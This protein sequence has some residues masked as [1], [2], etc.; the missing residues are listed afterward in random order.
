MAVLLGKW[1]G[2][3][4]TISVKRN[5]L[6][7]SIEQAQGE[8][9]VYSYDYA[10]RLWT[11]QLESTT[12]RRGL[13]GKMVAKWMRPDRT[14]GRRWLAPGE[15]RA[16]VEGR[17]RAQMLALYD[18]IRSGAAALSGSLDAQA[19]TGFERAI[20][21]DADRS[22]ADAAR[23]LD[24]YQPVGILPPDQYFSVVLQLAEGC[25]FNTCTFCTFYRDRAFRIK[26]PD[27][28]REHALA[29]R[30][31]LGD[32]LSLRRTIFLGDANALVIPMKLLLPLVDIVREVYD[33][34]RLG[35][36]YAFLDGFS[37]HKK[38]ASDYAA[39]RERGLKTVYIGMESGHAPL[40][41]FLKKPGQPEDVVEAVRAIK[42]GGVS[43]GVIV[44]L[45]AGG[46][47]Y[48]AAHVRDTID[49]INA[50]GLDMDDLIYFSELVVSEGMDYA[51]DAY[52]A[53]LTPLTPEERIA[54]GEQIERRLR[55]SPDGGVP[56]I[57][58][59]DI[60]EFVY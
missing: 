46:Q 3:P 9:D 12:Y 33:V 42:A 32:G 48:A 4:I 38:S 45:G 1:D 39:L 14:R 35:G 2:R 49:A 29:V 44:L 41:T 58:R 59:Y 52:D 23:Y 31:F 28:F 36:L 22:A 50:M 21:F 19:Q 7:V 56:H 10:G 16:E 18:A 5:C 8:P 34:D 6:T 55:F 57:S 40:L 24:V 17:A 43:V 27:A 20:A 25:S 15:A 60:R 53:G 54:Q 13:D 11:A 30:D 26:P 47:Q 37:G 51:R